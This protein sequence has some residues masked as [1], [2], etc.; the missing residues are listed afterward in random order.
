[1]DNLCTLGASRSK[2]LMC[3]PENIEQFLKE[4]SMKEIFYKSQTIKTCPQ[5]PSQ[6]VPDRILKNEV[7]EKPNRC[8]PYGA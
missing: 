5:R 8:L 2:S 4:N 6:A 1:M 7:S 3:I